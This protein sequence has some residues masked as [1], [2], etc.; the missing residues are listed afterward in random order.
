MSGNSHHMFK[1]KWKQEKVKYK[2]KMNIT[3][4]RCLKLRFLKK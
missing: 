1:N 3:V 4:S 2:T